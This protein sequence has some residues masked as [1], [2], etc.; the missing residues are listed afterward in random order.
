VT[1]TPALLVASIACLLSAACVSMQSRIANKEDLLAAAGFD[2]KPANTPNRL[3]ELKSLPPNRFVPRAK[4]EHVE[5]LYADPVVCNCLY[6][7]DQKAYNS[8]K[9]EIYQRNLA[10]EQ[11]LTAEMYQEPP[12]FW[13]G[14]SWGPWGWPGPWWW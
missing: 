7:G 9:R 1:K 11:Q 5:Y 13:Y 12:A 6:V 2:V 14:W 4:G 10:D 8:Y 3:A